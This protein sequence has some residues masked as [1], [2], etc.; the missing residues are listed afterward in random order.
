MRDSAR[1]AGGRFSQAIQA[2]RAIR[3]ARPA[4][5]SARCQSRSSFRHYARSGRTRKSRRRR[6]ATPTGRLYGTHHRDA[7]RPSVS[8][9]ARRRATYPRSSLFSRWIRHRTLHQIP[10]P[11]RN[12][13][14][15]S[16][17]G[18]C[19]CD[20]ERDRQS[21]RCTGSARPVQASRTVDKGGFHRPSSQ[22]NGPKSSYE[23]R[24]FSR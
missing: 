18:E 8:Y 6:C 2:V 21:T 23:Y 19:D 10:F 17:D 20:T 22:P 11:T 14:P 9:Q 4:A 24:A 1:S 12:A 16:Q 15:D 3:T 7:A 13:H 5:K